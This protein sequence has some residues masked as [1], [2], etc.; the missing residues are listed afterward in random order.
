[1]EES[2]E[3]LKDFDIFFYYGQN[4]LLTE[5]KSD[6]MANIMQGKRS[7]FFNRHLDSSGIQEYENA[8]ISLLLQTKIP[9]DIVNSIALRNQYVSNGEGDLPD[10]RV[11]ITQ[12]NIKLNSDKKGSLDVVVYYTPLATY[13]EE[14]ASIGL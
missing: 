13:A 10:R 12:N 11:A 6:V 14:K 9:Y 8:P 7:L 4:D 1:M 5:I 2:L 3:V